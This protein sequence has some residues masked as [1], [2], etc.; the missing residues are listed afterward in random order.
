MLNHNIN[1]KQYE[2]SPT[3]QEKKKSQNR[4]EKHKSVGPF[5]YKWD[6][7]LIKF[8]KPLSREKLLLL[9]ESFE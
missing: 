3:E 6:R 5:Q 7:K 8:M 9:R 1:M 2:R 4:R